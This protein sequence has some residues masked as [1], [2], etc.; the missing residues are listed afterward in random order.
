[1]SEVTPG[2]LERRRAEKLAAWEKRTTPLIVIAAI[3]PFLP[4]LTSGQREW[5]SGTVELAAW[6]VFA[7]DLVVHVRLR[8]HYLRTGLG[9]FD[10]VIV[11]ATFPW[12][13]IPGLGG[14]AALGLMRLGR[15]V[16]I[17]LAGAK[18]PALNLLLRRLGAPA[19]V[20][21]VAV[22]LAGT[23]VHRTEPEEFPTYGDGVWWGFVT[24]STVGYG[25]FVPDT[26]T[27][28]VV[29]V[30]LMMVGVALLGTVAASLSSFLAELRRERRAAG[31][32][33]GEPVTEEDR[34]ADTLE[35]LRAEIAALREQIGSG[36]KPRAGP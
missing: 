8:P 32:T 18:S 24:V 21:A 17:L 27:G 29:A 34:L 10:A 6:A 3:V 15:L 23:I 16:R 14:T 5:I 13:L 20:V 9:R 31:E 22:V 1:M 30:L 35:Q 19:L 36:G 11:V 26:G 7:V 12:Y 33:E 28:R 4:A 25:D 2:E